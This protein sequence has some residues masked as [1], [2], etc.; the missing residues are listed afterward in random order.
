MSGKAGL[1]HSITGLAHKADYA[2]LLPLLARLPLPVAYAL[3]AVRGRMNGWLGRDWRS[4]AL[5]TRHIARKSAQGYTML[6]KEAP[7]ASVQTLVRQRFATESREEFEG[8]L[9]INGR[10]P[11]LHCDIE[12]EAF[13][14]ACLQRDRGLLLL[15]PHFDSF[16]LGIAFLGL[17]GV[18]INVMTSSVTNDARVDP[19]VSRHFFKKYRGMERMMNGGRMLDREDGVRPFYQMLERGECLVVLADSPATDG[20]AAESPHFLG[21]RRCLAGGAL[22]MARRTGSD[23]GA[24][25]CRFTEPGHYRLQSGPLLSAADPLALDAVYAF[26]SEQIMATPGRWWAADLLPEM[27]AVTA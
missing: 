1:M 27:P 15:T 4:M 19:A 2:L 5:Q 14:A 20:G 3:S 18:K 12:S 24:F 7:Q 8:H 10:V 9:I 13:L 11:E 6:L 23:I 22:R 16:M 17:T 26:L 25:V 21:A